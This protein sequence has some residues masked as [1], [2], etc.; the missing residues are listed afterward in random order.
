MVMLDW[1][2]PVLRL[3]QYKINFTLLH[4]LNLITGRICTTTGYLWKQ[5]LLQL[6]YKEE[7]NAHLWT[8]SSQKKAKEG[9]GQTNKIFN[10]FHLITHM[11]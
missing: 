1:R 5:G 7:K 3:T 9:R 4:K 11:N 8:A 10:L 2:K 6:Q